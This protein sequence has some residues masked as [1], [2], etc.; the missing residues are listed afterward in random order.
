MSSK[1]GEWSSS[2]LLHC[3]YSY[4]YI[5]GNYIPSIRSFITCLHKRFLNIM[6]NIVLH[7]IFGGG[8]WVG[9][10]KWCLVRLEV[11]LACSNDVWAGGA[12]TRRGFCTLRLNVLCDAW[13]TMLCLGSSWWDSLQVMSWYLTLH[14]LSSLHYILKINTSMLLNKFH[15][16]L[17]VSIWYLH[18]LLFIVCICL[19]L[20]PVVIRIYS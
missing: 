7:S 6:T 14:S 3:H 9:V 16:Y 15:F 11:P 17:L 18:F 20:Y 19:N 1:E 10:S 13:G 2:C 5:C 8:D 4:K 12:H